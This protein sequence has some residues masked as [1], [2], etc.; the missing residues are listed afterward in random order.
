MLV[1]LLLFS[2]KA[3]GIMKSCVGLG[4]SLGLGV[5]IKNTNKKNFK[6]CGPWSF[7][8]LMASLFACWDDPSSIASLVIFMY[9]W[10]TS[11]RPFRI[12]ARKGFS[13]EPYYSQ[14]WWTYTRGRL[15]KNHTLPDLGISNRGR[16]SL[17][18]PRPNC[19]KVGED[20]KCWTI[21]F[22]A[23]VNSHKR[24]AHEE[25]YYSGLG[26]SN[27]RRGSLCW[28]PPNCTKVG[29]DFNGYDPAGNSNVEESLRSTLCPV[30]ATASSAESPS[31]P[32]L[33]SP[34]VA[35]KTHRRRL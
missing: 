33:A 31:E 16:G 29:A 24:E 17:C 6:C 22:S 27:Q 2:S 8:L 32:S 15:T 12:E 30:Y 21:L 1:P 3:W 7:L 10:F 18:W 19:T 13:G 14:P 4:L 34:N 11:P 23:L 26:V 28:P 35:C 9:F 20:F 5:H 25:P